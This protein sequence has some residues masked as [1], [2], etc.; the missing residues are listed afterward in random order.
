MTPPRLT[1]F[2]TLTTDHYALCNLLDTSEP[3]LPKS[4]KVSPLHKS[5]KSYRGFSWLPKRNGNTRK[6]AIKRSRLDHATRWSTI[7]TTRDFLF[8]NSIESSKMAIMTSLSGKE[9][10]SLTIVFIFLNVNTEWLRYRLPFHTFANITLGNSCQ[11]NETDGKE[12]ECF[13]EADRS[14]KDLRRRWILGRWW[15]N[16][17]RCSST[18]LRGFIWEWKRFIGF[19]GRVGN[20]NRWVTI[21]V[22]V[23]FQGTYGAS[24]CLIPVIVPL[25]LAR[26]L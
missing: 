17:D 6:S 23:P 18:W 19:C 2:S 15:R 26:T 21:S 3:L 16:P 22:W 11:A 8:M 12:H 14:W 7:W 5:M 9:S 4:T 24:S 13:E 25:L 1:N 10:L 20:T